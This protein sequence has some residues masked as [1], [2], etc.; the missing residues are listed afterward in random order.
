MNKLKPGP[1]IGLTIITFVMFSLIS[2]SSKQKANDQL[3]IV[4]SI[5]PYEILVRQIVGEEYN[6]SSFI[7][8]DA[9]PHTYSPTPNDLKMLEN[10]DLIISNGWGLEKHLEKF[11][12][13]LGNK[14]ISVDQFIIDHLSDS[15]K[16]ITDQVKRHDHDSEHH[17]HGSNPHF[18]LD[19]I[20]L[21]QIAAGITEKLIELDP[22]NEEHYLSGLAEILSN[23]NH[24]DSVVR[25]E[26]KTL[27]EINVMNF[28]DAFYYFNRR[29]D[30]NSIGSIIA[31][32]GKEPT[33]RELLET[34]QLIS[35]YKV[36]V[37]FIEPQLNPKAAQI[38]AQ[39]HGV[40]VD[41]LDPL[42]SYFKVKSIRDLF[43]SNWNQI[44]K[45]YPER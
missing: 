6:V 24:I 43:L 11:L 45:H 44:K 38:I 36:K 23:L 5:Y 37:I 7:P 17:H 21:K 34:G 16:N 13:D 15:H 26:R 28:H 18:W 19:P 10:A 1:I 33:P 35:R 9:S 41:F 4:T 25:E 42:G 8:A 40:K 3:I 2:C 32:P 31:S 39:E 29:Y 30:I 12:V 14:H 22:E 27:G 20:L